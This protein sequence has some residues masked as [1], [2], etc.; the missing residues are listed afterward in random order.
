VIYVV[1]ASVAAEYL[2]KTD[3]GLKLEGVIDGQD[4]AAPDLLDVEVL[5]VMRRAVRTARLDAGRAESALADLVRWPIERI[6][7][8]DLVMEAWAHRHNV[9]AYDAFY[10][11]AAR[12]LGATLLTTDGPLSRAKRLG[13]AIQYLRLS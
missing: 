8:V 4:V 11:A 1:D 3:L 9:T 2:L 12:R 13:V 6:P 5:S 7:S 10:V